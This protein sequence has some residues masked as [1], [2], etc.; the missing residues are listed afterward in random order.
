MAGALACL[1]FGAVALSWVWTH[2]G[3]RFTVLPDSPTA[4]NL[5]TVTA[6]GDPGDLQRRVEHCAAQGHAVPLER[7]CRTQNISAVKDA[8]DRC[9]MCT[10]VIDAAKL[11]LAEESESHKTRVEELD[12]KA[13]FTWNEA[14]R[15]QPAFAAL[16]QGRGNS[17]WKSDLHNAFRPLSAPT[18]RSASCS[19]TV[20]ARPAADVS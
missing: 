9:G 11:A 10:G 7:V 6:P 17:R 19:V 12:G 16:L 15:K 20:A 3:Q 18:S 2:R 5:L 8:L 4:A 14:V 1:C 13:V